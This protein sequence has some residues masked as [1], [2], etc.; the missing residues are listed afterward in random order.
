LSK[1]CA[2]LRS[3]SFPPLDILEGVV[4]LSNASVDF[5]LVRSNQL[6]VGFRHQ[7]VQLKAIVNCRRIAIRNWFMNF[8]APGTYI[9]GSDFI[10]T[11]LSTVKQG[12]EKRVV[13]DDF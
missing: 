1:F 13:A 10:M 7:V 12:I 8:A 9:P 4:E 11:R 2:V 6:C 3:E 5:G